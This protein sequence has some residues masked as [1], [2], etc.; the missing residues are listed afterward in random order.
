MATIL[1][2]N[3][4]QFLLSV[5]YVALNGLFTTL[6]LVQERSRYAHH[7]AALRILESHCSQRSTYFFQPPYRLGI[8]L[9]VFSGFVHEIIPQSIFIIEKNPSDAVG[10]YSLTK[11]DGLLGEGTVAC[12]YSPLGVMITVLAGFALIYFAVGLALARNEAW[13]TASDQLQCGH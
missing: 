12:R 9:M 6:P 2:A 5:L 10:R 3:L 8:P 1:I 4:L 13:N 7:R 11:L